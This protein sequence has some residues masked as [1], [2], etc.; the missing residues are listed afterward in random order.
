MDTQ[1]HNLI[2]LFH[3]FF[4]GSLLIYVGI[5]HDKLYK[6]IYKFLIFL[7]LVIISFHSYKIYTYIQLN[8]SYWINIIHIF[9]FAPLLV[10]IGYNEDKTPR[11][12]YEILLMLGFAAI[13]YNGYYLY[14]LLSY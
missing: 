2:Y 6:P 7:G 14:K 12:Y 13:G 1:N 4:V 5:N 8:K 11:M 9:I 10:Y 3:I